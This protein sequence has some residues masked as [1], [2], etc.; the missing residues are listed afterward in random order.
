MI[1]FHRINVVFL[2]NN[3]VLAHLVILYRYPQAYSPNLPASSKYTF[4]FKIDNSEG[5]PF[6]FKTSGVFHDIEKLSTLQL[7]DRLANET[8]IRYKLTVTYKDPPITLD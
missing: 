6:T 8:I 2:V 1:Y 7:P 4:K 3:Y 5:E